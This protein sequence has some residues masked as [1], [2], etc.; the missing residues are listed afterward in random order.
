MAEPAQ[1]PRVFISY[2][3]ADSSTLA[4][5]LVGLLKLAGFEPY[6]DTHDIAKAEDWEARLGALILR[7]D[8]VVFVISPASVASRRCQW[9]VDKTVELGKRLIPVEWIHVP[10][11]DV[12]E[13]L[14]RLNY[15][16][17]REGQPF[18]RPMA[19]L[20]TAL[21][22]DVAWIR[23]HTRL[24]EEAARWQAR[25]AGNAEGRA[26]GSADFQLL[27]GDALAEA[28][29]WVLRRKDGAPEVTELQRAYIA[30]SEAREADALGEERARLAERE[31]LVAEAEQAAGVA[32]AAAEQT[33]RSQRGRCDCCGVWPRW[34]WRC[35]WA[36][37]GR[38]ARRRSGSRR[39]IRDLPP[40]R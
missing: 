25:L 14:R 36:R 20:A 19:Q 17:F 11:A 30:A 21:S 28:K 35:L 23:E 6:L 5:E 18:A 16:I 3:R 9:E 37:S 27:R 7:A 10:E 26:E 2:A 1:K 13:K 34:C 40:R 12:P 33:A 32:R 4:E 31:R 15:T 24:G 8:T 22:Q 39:F 38:R 29:A